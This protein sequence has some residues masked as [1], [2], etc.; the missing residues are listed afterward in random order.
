MKDLKGIR[1]ALMQHRTVFTIPG[2]R[3]DYNGNAIEF[4][5]NVMSGGSGNVN[6]DDLYSIDERE[7]FG[8]GMNV[9]KFGPTCVTLYT[10]DML[11]KKT[12]GK[13]KYDNVEIITMNV[14]LLETV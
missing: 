1:E 8:R 10:Y 3:I 6:D 2:I 11:G 7:I 5:T 9:T 14:P 12:L 4:I 13:I